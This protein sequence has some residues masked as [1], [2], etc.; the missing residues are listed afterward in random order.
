[1]DRCKLCNELLHPE[2]PYCP[3]CG[4]ERIVDSLEMASR[5]PPWLDQSLTIAVI[6]I[7]CWL[8]ITIAVA[9]LREAKALRRAR[10]ALQTNQ[11]EV[12]DR[13]ISSWV[14]KHPDDPETLFLAGNIAIKRGI[15]EG[16][17]DYYKRLETL[18]DDKRA[19]IRLT[20]M[21]AIYQDQIP[22]NAMTITCGQSH[23]ADFYSAYSA[24][25]E[26]FK[27]ALLDAAANLTRKCV[28]QGNP[29][30][31]N[32]PGFWL[33]DQDKFPTREIVSK[34]YI[35]PMTH[36][37]EAGDYGLVE[38]LAFQAIT[39]LPET[40]KE[41]DSLLEDLRGDVHRNAQKLQNICSAIIKNHT[42]RVDG[43]RC[44]PSSMPE[45]YADSL[46]AWGKPLA[47]LPADAENEDTCQ[48]SF[49]VM[50]KGTGQLANNG[51]FAPRAFNPSI[52][53]TCR[54]GPYNRPSLTPNP[55]RFWLP[56]KG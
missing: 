28:N 16:S 7:S 27:P 19:Q 23:Y 3:K 35:A 13:W 29:Q 30:V 42:T 26:S 8:L 46:D 31:A 6:T 2:R 47:Y 32:E 4:K 33:I 20:K 14:S 37:I 39:Q 34:L 49:L 43:K 15:H 41:V 56:Q 18:Q 51:R 45:E 40:K 21:T 53:I 10:V 55:S 38:H 50:S 1:M 9:F 25:N 24:T 54:P 44:Y 36:D 11:L 5:R 22:K 48:E 52:P 12:A 17:I